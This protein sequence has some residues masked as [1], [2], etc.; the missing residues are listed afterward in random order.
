M[1]RLVWIPVY[2]SAP[3]PLPVTVPQP[4]APGKSRCGNYDRY[5][6]GYYGGYGGYPNYFGGYIEQRYPYV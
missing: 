3:H 5:H 4:P 1:R 6:G 2:R